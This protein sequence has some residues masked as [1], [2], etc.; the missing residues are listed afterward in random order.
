MRLFHS[1]MYT[2]IYYSSNTNKEESL[3]EKEFH[4]IPLNLS[5]RHWTLLFV[6]LK[7]K[8][9]Y[10]LDRLKQH[11]D[12]DLVSKASII[13]NII[14]EKKFG[15]SKGCSIASLSHFL[16]KDAVRCGVLLCYYASQIVEGNV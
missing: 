10:I 6:N 5:N 2:N 7:T 8:T 4:F 12:A 3:S 13:T 15:Y 1:T 14:L 9:L 16:Q 11:A